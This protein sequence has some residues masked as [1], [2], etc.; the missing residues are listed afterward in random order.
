MTPLSSPSARSVVFG[1][2]VAMAT[3]KKHSS[4][5]SGGGTG[6]GK[7]SVETLLVPLIHDS[8]TFSVRQNKGLKEME[9]QAEA[10]M[11][12]RRR[13]WEREVDRMR[14]EFLRLYPVPIDER[15]PQPPDPLV[16]KRRGS[17]DILDTKK[18]QTMIAEHTAAD[19]ERKFRLRFDVSGF[20]VE[21]IEVLAD[22]QRI[23][24][25]AAKTETVKGRA[26]KR[27][28]IRK[29][30]N[31]IDVDTN[32]LTSHLTTDGILVV[33]A[34]LQ[35]KP[36]LQNKVSDPSTTASPHHLRRRTSSQ[37]TPGTPHHNPAAAAAEAEAGTSEGAEGTVQNPEVKLGVPVFRDERGCR[38]LYLVVYIGTLFRPKDVTVQ[39]IKD[40]RIVVKARHEEISSER[41]VKGKFSKEFELAEKIETESVRGG[42]DDEGRLVVGAFVKGHG[43]D[44]VDEEQ[45]EEPEEFE[46][47]SDLLQC[48]VLNLSSFPPTM[49][50]S[51]VILSSNGNS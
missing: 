29:I 11:K 33:E 14:E 16:A 35:P 3:K 44:R 8:L 6:S 37:S 49:P 9:R 32:K 7:S 45:E 31:P 51:A 5:S 10:E 2:S 22:A 18:M 25:Q 41:L 24:V 15:H 40:N 26:V 30:Q 38:R 47:K 39:V 17:T 27:Q 34:S 4:S 13:D 19:A 1:I 48:N 43:K 28:F 20:D 36:H 42:I 23:V 21:T 46:P 12:R 50:A